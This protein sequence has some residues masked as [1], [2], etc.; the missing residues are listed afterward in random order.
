MTD[1]KKY[2]I[3]VNKIFEIVDKMKLSWTDQDNLNYLKKI[4]DYKNIVIETSKKI[5]QDEKDQQVEELGK[6]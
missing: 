3:A 4:E 1:Y 2:V 5:S 6:W